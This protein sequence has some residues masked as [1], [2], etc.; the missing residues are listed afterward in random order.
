MQGLA[1]H[2]ASERN[3]LL[4]RSAYAHIIKNA[5]EHALILSE[6]IFRILHEPDVNLR[7]LQ[8][9]QRNIAASG[10][11]IVGGGDQNNAFKTKR[12][13]LIADGLDMLLSIWPNRYAQQRPTI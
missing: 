13:T 1:E 3:F 5:V 11:H 7:L 8:R 2:P 4:I 12:H 9:D 6:N 10:A